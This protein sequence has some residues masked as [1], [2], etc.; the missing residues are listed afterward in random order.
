MYNDSNYSGADINRL[1]IHHVKKSDEG[2]YRCLVKNE[3]IKDGIL[4]KEA[5]LN[6]CKFVLYSV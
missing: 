4:S 5:Q 3:V 2:C 6:V 1:S